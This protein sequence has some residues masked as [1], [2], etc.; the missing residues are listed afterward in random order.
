[1]HRTFIFLVVII[2]VLAFAQKPKKLKKKE[3]SLI[4]AGNPLDTLRVLL[5]TNIEDSAFLRK[6]SKDISLEK[7]EGEVRYFSKRLVATMT[8]PKNAG[9]G[10]AAPQVGLQRNIIC[11]QRFDKE[12]TPNEIFI[13]PVIINCSDSTQ[14]GTEG[15]LSIPDKKGDVKRAAHIVV[16][17]LDLVGKKHIEEVTGFTAVIFQHEIDHL[18]GILFIDHLKK[19]RVERVMKGVKH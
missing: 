10:I 3:K 7:N 12:N 4:E 11:I 5:I 9:V 17:Y 19:T 14:I 13:N 15:C 1:M 8:H 2:P 18:R 16:E 6:T